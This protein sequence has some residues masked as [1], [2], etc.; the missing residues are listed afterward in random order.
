MKSENSPKTPTFPKRRDDLL[1]GR[2]YVQEGREDIPFIVTDERN[3]VDLADGVQ[4]DIN[5]EPD[6]ARFRE[7]DAK[8]VIE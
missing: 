2:V 6:T 3:S 4:W 8:V 5:L 1:E 7:L